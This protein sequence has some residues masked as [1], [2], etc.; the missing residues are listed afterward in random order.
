LLLLPAKLVYQ[1]CMQTLL[2]MNKQKKS[3]PRTFKRWNFLFIQSHAYGKT[4]NYT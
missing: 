1:S 2:Q 4:I 3:F